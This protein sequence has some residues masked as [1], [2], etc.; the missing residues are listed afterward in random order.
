MAPELPPCNVF[1]P[2][3]LGLARERQNDASIMIVTGL[4]SILEDY[5]AYAAALARQGIRVIVP[6]CNEGIIGTNTIDALDQRI[7]VIQISIEKLDAPI[8]ANPHSLG[9]PV[10]ALALGAGTES[11]VNDLVKYIKSISFMQ[12]AGF[13][14]HG[15]SDFIHALKFFTGEAVERTV[16]LIPIV[17]KG[18]WASRERFHISKRAGEVRGLWRLDEQYMP[19]AVQSL[20]D[21]RVP[22]KFYLGPRDD[23]TRAVPIRNAVV[24]IVGERNVVDVHP[25]AGHIPAVTHPDRMAKLVFEGLGAVYIDFSKREVA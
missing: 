18:G 1:S 24:P 12:P 15:P 16:K 3:D 21:K 5:A 11:G 17:F 7:E 23:L 8:H 10:I 6:N 19:A 20:D 22:M 14:N 13:E 2:V 9:A 4:G 25:L